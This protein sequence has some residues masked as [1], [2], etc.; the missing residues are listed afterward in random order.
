MTAYSC[1]DL[2]LSDDEMSQVFAILR[3]KVRLSG[4]ENQLVSFLSK[5]LYRALGSRPFNCV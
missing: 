5:L 1:I 4:N 2:E 3:I